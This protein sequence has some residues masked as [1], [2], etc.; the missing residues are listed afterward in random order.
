[1][2]IILIPIAITVI[3]FL[4]GMFALGLMYCD[5]DKRLKELEERR[6]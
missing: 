6:Q 2:D 1:M 4:G 5:L 3:A